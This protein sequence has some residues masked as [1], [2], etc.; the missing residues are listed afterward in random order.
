MPT[1]ANRLSFKPQEA[2]SG[3][4]AWPRL[5]DLCGHDPIYGLNENRHGA[6]ISIDR[7]ALITRVRA[8]LNPELSDE[9]AKRIC[10]GLMRAVTAFDPVKCRKL[11]LAKHYFSETNVRR[12]SNLPFDNRWCYWSP[13]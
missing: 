11:A 8:Y 9:E 5:T 6:M 4:L 10:P 2:S 3:Y 1:K 12:F 7:E 13:V